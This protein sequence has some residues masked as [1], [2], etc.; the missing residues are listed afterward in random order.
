[1]D[2]HEPGIASHRKT[3]VRAEL[4]ARAKREVN[5]GLRI[6]HLPSAI[7]IRRGRIVFGAL[8]GVKGAP[9]V[10]S[11]KAKPGVHSGVAQRVPEDFDAKLSG[12][13]GAGPEATVFEGWG[14]GPEEGI[15]E[16]RAHEPPIV[17]A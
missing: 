15:L 6:D 10:S 3:Q 8:R 17:D 4:H 16:E 12:V 11:P 14:V 9:L 5:S 2:A 1:M 13:R 7:G